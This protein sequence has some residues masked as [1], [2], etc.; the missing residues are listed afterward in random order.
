MARCARS[1]AHPPLERRLASTPA[2]K[3][4]ATLC[5]QEQFKP[6]PDGRCARLDL[7]PKE[8]KKL[9]S[10][11]QHQPHTDHLPG[12]S[13]LFLSSLE[14]PGDPP[15]STCCIVDQQPAD[16]DRPCCSEAIETTQI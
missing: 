3:G 4:S 15:A 10:D 12:F 7:P 16:P 1:S 11:Q 8:Q 13:R 2:Q 9:Q 5:A 14:E 6:E